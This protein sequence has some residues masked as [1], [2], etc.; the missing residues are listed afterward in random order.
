M[1]DDDDLESDIEIAYNRES[2]SLY[3]FMHIIQYIRS[4]GP[5]SARVLEIT[6]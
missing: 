2:L 3:T 4:S 6:M 1:V 5:A